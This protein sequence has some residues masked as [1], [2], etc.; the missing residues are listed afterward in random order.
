VPPEGCGGCIT[1]KKLKSGAQL[2]ERGPWKAGIAERVKILRNFLEN[3]SKKVFKTKFKPPLC[4]L[5]V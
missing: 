5:S 4:K 3:W 2:E 1:P